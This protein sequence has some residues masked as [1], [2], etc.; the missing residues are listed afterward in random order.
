MENLIKF[1]VNRIIQGKM[2]LD[3]VPA[4]WRDEVSAALENTSAN[5]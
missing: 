4:K 3:R 5:G 1:Y 2:T